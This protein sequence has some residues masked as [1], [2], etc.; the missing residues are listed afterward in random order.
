MS[1]QSDYGELILDP[2]WAVFPSGNDIS[3]PLCQDC[4]FASYWGNHN[5]ST[6]LSFLVVSLWPSI[7]VVVCSQVTTSMHSCT[8]ANSLPCLKLGL[9]WWCL[10]PRLFLFLSLSFLPGLICDYFA[11]SLCIVLCNWGV[12]LVL[13]LDC[14]TTHSNAS[15]NSNLH[16]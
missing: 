9:Q 14:T 2:G 4:Y 16:F 13:M 12:Y 7:I 3:H 1:K 6:L 8:V 5:K 15:Y 10:D 11:Y